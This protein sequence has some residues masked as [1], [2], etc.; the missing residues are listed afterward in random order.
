MN[1]LALIGSISYIIGLAIIIAN[2][3]WQIWQARM[4][5]QRLPRISTDKVLITGLMLVFLGIAISTNQTWARIV[6]IG[7][8]IMSIIFFY[9]EIFSRE[10]G[11]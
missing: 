1:I 9:L 10:K 11:S 3:G 5:Q 8:T 4:Q 6:F 2:L 7:L